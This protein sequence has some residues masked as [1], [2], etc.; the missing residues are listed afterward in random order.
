MP[1]ST[2]Q[3]PNLP[4]TG[5]ELKT[6]CCALLGA[7]LEMR[8]VPE[9]VT[10]T[11]VD[12]LAVAM[13]NDFLFLSGTSYPNVRVELQVRLHYR[14]NELEYSLRPVIHTTNPLDKVHPVFVRISSFM[15]DRAGAKTEAFTLTATVDNPNLVRVHYGIP[16]TLSRR[17][18]PNPGQMFAEIVTET[19]EYDPEEFEPPAPPTVKDETGEISAAYSA[20]PSTPSASAYPAA[21][22]KGKGWNKNRKG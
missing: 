12:A 10:G 8:S 1:I 7:E 20:K 2:L 15:A 13:G 3:I 5:P 11:L 9:K 17:K 16:I 21:P 22:G 18:D 19:L 6:Y 14:D 4:L